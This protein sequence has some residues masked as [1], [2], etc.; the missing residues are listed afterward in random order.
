MRRKEKEVTDLSEKLSI[1][2]KCQVCRLAVIDTEKKSLFEDGTPY[3]VPLNFGYEY[4]LD[5]L[6]MYF[7]TATEGRLLSALKNNDSVCFE[8]DTSHRLVENS[9]ACAYSY[10]YESIIGEGTAEIVTDDREK[11]HGL[12]LIMER[13]TGKTGFEYSQ[14]SLDSTVVFKVD[15]DDF[16]AKK[17]Y[18]EKD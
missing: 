2:D 5:R 15:T 14:K 4:V 9:S 7:H 18:I 1:L 10:G 13:M 12:D 8:L 11:R 3:I 17:S 6:V 16:T